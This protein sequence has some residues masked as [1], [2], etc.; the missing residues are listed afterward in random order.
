VG[1]EVGSGGGCPWG[2]RCLGYGGGWPVWLG[3][4]VPRREGGV[5]FPG[6]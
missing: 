4:A 3:A 6:S 2:G 1:L 5:L